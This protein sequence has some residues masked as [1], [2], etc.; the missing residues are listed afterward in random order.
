MGLRTFQIK[1]DSTNDLECFNF[2]LKGI[3]ESV[4]SDIQ[5]HNVQLS[6]AVVDRGILIVK[7][8][9]LGLCP[10]PLRGVW[11]YS[12]EVFLI[13]LHQFQTR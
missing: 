2:D 8:L 6:N 1:S 7:A 4:L 9:S 5:N 12:K 11:I 13:G 3:V 10:K